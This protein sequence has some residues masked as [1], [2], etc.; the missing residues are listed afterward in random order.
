MLCIQT[1][2][3]SSD[4]V[5]VNPKNVRQFGIA[6]GEIKQLYVKSIKDDKLFAD[7]INGMLSGLDPHSSYLDKETLRTLKAHT[8]GQ[9]SGLGIEVTLEKGMI[10]IISPIDDTPAQKAGLKPGDYI[11]AVNGKPL[12]KTTIT[13][14]ISLLRGKKG[15]KVTLTVINPK[16]KKPRKITVKR[17]VIHIKSIKSKML[18]DGFG[19]IRITH[20]QKG[21]GEKMIQALEKLQKQAHGHLNGLILDLR[22]NAGGLMKPSI[23]VADTF[24]DSEKLG[25]NSRIVYT[26]GRTPQAN[27]ADYATRG[28][29][30]SGAPIVVLINEGSASASEIVAG[31][32]QD[33]KRALIVGHRSFGKGSVQTVLP[34]SEDS[35][36]KLTTALYYT[37]KGRSIQAEGIEPDIV[38]DTLKLQKEKED[39]LF[40]WKMHEEDL[41]GHLKNGNGHKAKKTHKKANLHKLATSDY[42]LYEALQILK[43]LH[44]LQNRQDG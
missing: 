22:N 18:T 5:T 14:A 35:A 17:D 19:Y 4:Q 41:A 36:I 13:K 11:L 12:I 32:L 43:S 27:T 30:L 28:D 3:F 9:F 2:A 21:T 25:D 40:F 24:L 34:I 37:P 10:K 26:K 23:K 1:Q 6:I 16:D 33:H 38:V 15:T 8:Y 42:Q 7:A 39:V 44:I 20:F 29:L 31:A